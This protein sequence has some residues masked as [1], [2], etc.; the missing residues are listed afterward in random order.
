MKKTFVAITFLIVTQITLLA[1]KDGFFSDYYDDNREIFDNNIELN[2]QTFGQAPIGGGL[3]ILVLS[4][5]SY[6]II[7]R[8]KND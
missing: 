3:A 4:G 2:N 1:Q 5:I 7:K 8:N 6:A